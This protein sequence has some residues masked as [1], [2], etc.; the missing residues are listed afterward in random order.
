MPLTTPANSPVG[1]PE[2]RFVASGEQ[3]GVG[4]GHVVARVGGGYSTDPS[5]QALFAATSKI[6]QQYRLQDGGMFNSSLANH[7]E[8]SKRTVQETH[9]FLLDKRNVDRVGVQFFENTSPPRRPVAWSQIAAS[10]CDVG[11]AG[12]TQPPFVAGDMT[13]VATHS[14]FRADGGVAI[15]APA[16]ALST[17]PTMIAPLTYVADDSVASLDRPTFTSTNK[18]RIAKTALS[19]SAALP[20]FQRSLSPSHYGAL[21]TTATQQQQLAHRNSSMVSKLH[22]SATHHHSSLNHSAAASRLQSTNPVPVALDRTLHSVDGSCC[23]YN[24]P[25]QHAQV[26]GLFVTF[27]ENNVETKLFNAIRDLDIEKSGREMDSK[28]HRQQLAMYLRQIEDLTLHT[29]QLKKQLEA[30]HTEHREEA[31]DLRILKEEYEKKFRQRTEEWDALSKANATLTAQL[32][33]ANV[34]SGSRAQR[35]SE[36]EKELRGAKDNQAAMD[37]QMKELQ[38]RLTAALAKASVADDARD[39]MFVELSDTKLLLAA[40]EQVICGLQSALRSA[41]DKVSGIAFMRQEMRDANRKKT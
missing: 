36:L 2:R 31:T 24:H 39:K 3:P 10:T 35:I 28:M 14:G 21:N 12:G 7:V 40:K 27:C 18:T 32:D 37:R 4:R 33:D 38:D 13:S 8:S 23:N 25:V 5:A 1:T 26:E 19:S 9:A 22:R 6:A 11:P 15:S 29:E 34:V 30:T 41:E 16:H 17:T 20:H